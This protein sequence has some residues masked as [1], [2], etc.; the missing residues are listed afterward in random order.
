MSS[1]S[2]SRKISGQREFRLQEIINICDVLKISDPVEIFLKTITQI[3]S[4]RLKKQHKKLTTSIKM[5][6][7]LK[8]SKGKLYGQ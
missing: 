5:V 4:I 8:L 2:L 3:R 7:F 6:N 1:N